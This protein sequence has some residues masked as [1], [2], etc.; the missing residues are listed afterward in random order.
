ML[1]AAA[2][3]TEP[4]SPTITSVGPANDIGRAN[5]VWKQRVTLAARFGTPAL[6]PAIENSGAQQLAANLDDSGITGAL[7]AAEIRDDPNAA[8]ARLQ[9]GP[10]SALSWFETGEVFESARRSFPPV[11]KAWLRDQ[12]LA[13]S[14]DAAG[15]AAYELSIGGTAD[16]RAVIEQRLAKFRQHASDAGIESSSI[17]RGQP[18]LRSFQCESMDIGAGR[19][20][21]SDARLCHRRLP[22]LSGAVVRC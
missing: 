9:H 13:G 4:A 3:G 1:A 2:A 14:D 11:V 8:L 6:L 20:C 22:W 21:D 5:F 7:L 15:Q 12:V 19:A 10:P 16:D 18:R 17:A